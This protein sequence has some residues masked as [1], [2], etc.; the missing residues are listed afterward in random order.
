M[1][2]IIFKII[3]YSGV[4][5]LIRIIF[6]RNKVTII[7]FHEMTPATAEINFTYLKKYYNIISLQT[8][9]K[10]IENKDQSLLPKKSIIITF[11]DGKISNY[12]ILPIIK[13]LNIPV[14]IFLNSGIINTNRHFWFSYNSKFFSNEA[15]KKFSN[16]DRLAFMGQ[17]NFRQDQEYDYPQ[18]LNKDQITEMNKYIDLQSHTVLHPCLTKCD[19]DEAKFEITNCKIILEKEYGFNINSLAFPNGDYSDREIEIAKKAGY[20]FCLTVDKGYNT[21]SSDRYR[22]KRL[23]TNDT[24]N[25]DEFIVKI[26]GIQ[27]LFLKTNKFFHLFKRLKT[28]Y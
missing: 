23:D 19:N 17:H 1:R 28:N 22:L 20:K 14:T 3:R 15:L 4:P 8:F 16:K 21:I 12:T 24:D 2:L 9:L 6:Q 11:D 5:T 7:T 26:S 10:A 27:S 13:K 25:L 18:A